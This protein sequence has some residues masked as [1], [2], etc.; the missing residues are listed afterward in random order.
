M[1]TATLPPPAPTAAAERWKII[2]D[3]IKGQIVVR[4][5]F[6]NAVVGSPKLGKTIGVP[7]H[8]VAL[9]RARHRLTGD[10][11]KLESDWTSGIARVQ[12]WD[13]E[14]YEKE[15]L[16]L[17]RNYSSAQHH[18][19][20]HDL[21]T[22]IYGAE[23]RNLARHMRALHDHFQDIMERGDEPTSEEWETLANLVENDLA[24]LPP[25]EPIAVEPQRSDANLETG[26]D[27]DVVRALTERRISPAKAREVAV[28]VRDCNGTTPSLDALAPIF[29][30]AVEK[31]KTARSAI[32]SVVAARG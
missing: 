1:T 16:R 30:G 28:L 27:A 12:D 23:A 17:L 8:E 25:L 21:I 7:I 20:E 5:I 31:A 22:G 3:R 13:L 15:R 14:D 10:D 29:N 9:I 26:I 18:G 6:V 24:G 19:R 4:A 11:V 32:E 2:P